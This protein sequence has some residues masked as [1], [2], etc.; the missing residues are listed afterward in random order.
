MVFASA[1]GSP[2]PR[3]R[4]YLRAMAELGPSPLRSGEWCMTPQ[5]GDTALTEP[6]FAS[7][8]KRSMP[9]LEGRLKGAS[10]NGVAATHSSEP[11]PGG[12]RQ[13][14]FLIGRQA[15]DCTWLCSNRGPW[16]TTA[17]LIQAG[18]DSLVGR[19]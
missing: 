4:D 14:Q 13:R 19:C 11:D 5:H 10:D 17:A 3:E 12:A 16:T 1:R 18:C 15:I 9:G 6:M 8:M 7:F 2:H